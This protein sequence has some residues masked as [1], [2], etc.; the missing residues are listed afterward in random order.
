MRFAIDLDG[1]ICNFSASL[2]AIANLRWPGKFPPDFTG[3]SDWD[4][5]QYLTK[6]QM[7]EVWRDIRNVPYFW[8]N[9]G[10]LPGL[11]ELQQGIKPDD[12]IF[13]I[14]SRVNTIGEPASVQSA[15]WLHDRHLWPR[16]GYSTV[17]QVADPAHKQHLFQGLG[18][19]YH[20]DDLA[21]TVS[22]LNATPG[23]TAFLLDQPWN[24]HADALL[25][26]H[27]VT[28]HLNIIRERETAN[29]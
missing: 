29:R 3:P 14:T 2:V 23:V 8:E 9:M 10:A 7:A 13:F 1:V 27:S 15:R 28:E 5:S 17:L 25:R 16:A 26:V 11:S 6:A 20:L 18:L 4:Y 21:P 22:E 12:E 24:R 19:K